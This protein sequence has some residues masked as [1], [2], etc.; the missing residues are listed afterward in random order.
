MRSRFRSCWKLSQRK[1]FRDAIESLSP[2][3]QAFCKAYR[4]LQLAGTLFAVCVVQIK[5]Q[6]EALLNLPPDGLTKEVQMCQDL[7]SMFIEYQI[8]SDLLIYDG[9]KDAAG[10]EII[11]AVK[12]HMAAIK[13]MIK[14]TER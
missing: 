11:T 7:M 14:A 9:D 6:L 2:E 5:P 3:Q 13:D 12:G 1:E 4:K 8:P 10:D